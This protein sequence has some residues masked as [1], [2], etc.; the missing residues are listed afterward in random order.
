LFLRAGV[1]HC[2]GYFQTRSRSR[3]PDRVR[4]GRIDLLHGPRA[5]RGGRCGGEFDGE[6]REMSGAV[7]RFKA[8]VVSIPAVAEHYRA[9]LQALR[10]ADVAHVICDTPR[11]LTGSID[12]D[13]AKHATEPQAARWDYGIGFKLSP[14][15]ERAIWVEVHP[16][17]SSGN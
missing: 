5:K 8:A 7:S 3:R 2:E 10:A 6:S 15:E 11:K 9:G 12:L 16:A 17:S 4:L 13:A 14:A 1:R